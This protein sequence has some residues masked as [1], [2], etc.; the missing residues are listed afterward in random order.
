MADTQDLNSVGQFAGSRITVALRV[1]KGLS[2]GSIAAKTPSP[3]RDTRGSNF[4]LISDEDTANQWIRFGM[5][6]AVVYSAY[7]AN[8]RRT[9]EATATSSGGSLQVVAESAGHREGVFRMGVFVKGIE[10]RE[11]LCKQTW[12]P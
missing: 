12:N 10:I 3:F 5:P 1:L 2:E 9:S 7:F 4:R 8:S 11:S 6:P